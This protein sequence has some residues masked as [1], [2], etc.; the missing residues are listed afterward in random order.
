METPAQTF[1]LQR[2]QHGDACNVD[3]KVSLISG[4]VFTFK[5]QKDYPIQ[6]IKKA[7]Q[8]AMGVPIHQQR[9]IFKDKEIGGRWEIIG[10]QSTLED[11]EIG[12]GSV[13]Q[14]AISTTDT[15]IHGYGQ[16]ESSGLPFCCLLYTSD[17]AD[18]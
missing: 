9:L 5:L 13:L 8:A 1:R 14:L 3:I 7:I 4:K 10:R 6:L 12:E 16:S 15:E 18:E 11:Y 17:A 2:L